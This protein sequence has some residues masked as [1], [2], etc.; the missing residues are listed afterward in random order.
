METV[1][2]EGAVEQ[3]AAPQATAEE[4]AP[5]RRSIQSPVAEGVEIVEPKLTLTDR[6]ETLEAQ[7]AALSEAFTNL[8]EAKPFEEE[9]AL[10]FVPE[11]D[12]PEE[13]V[14]AVHDICGKGFGVKTEPHQAGTSFRLTITPPPNLRELKDSKMT[15]SLGQEI[16][17]V[18]D[19]RVKIISLVEGVNGVKVYAEKVRDF[20]IKW[21]FKNGINYGKKV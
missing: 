10:G 1:G 15:N 4:G 6:V 9:E 19:R 21:A 18:N 5:V 16:T 13:Y 12:A 3:T 7:M 17:V 20:C 14:R 8:G 11:H 2:G